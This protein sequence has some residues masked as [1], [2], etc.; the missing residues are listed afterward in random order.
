MAVRW[1]GMIVKK[2]TNITPG[3]SVAE[4]LDVMFMWLGYHM[5][6]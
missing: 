4:T 1:T 3:I 2:Q 5:Q 6:P